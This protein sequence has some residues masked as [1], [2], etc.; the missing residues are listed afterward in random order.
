[1]LGSDKS[2]PLNADITSDAVEEPGKL[3]AATLK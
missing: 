3:K 2:K 1:M